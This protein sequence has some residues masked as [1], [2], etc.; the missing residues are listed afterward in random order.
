MLEEAS[1]PGKTEYRYN[2]LNQQTAVFTKDGGVQ[3]NRYDAEY[4]RAEVS[5]NGRSFRFLYYNGELLAESGPDG[6]VAGR[7]ILGYSVAAGWQKEK[8]GYHSYHLDEQNSTAYITGTR[9]GIENSYQYDAFGVIRGRQEGIHNRILYTG[10]QHDQVTEQYY[11]RAR[12]YNPVVGRFL[13]EDVYR[14]DGL[15]L[16]AYCANNPVIYYDPSGFAKRDRTNPKVNSRTNPNIDYGSINQYGQRSGVIAKITPEMIGT[17]TSA[18]GRIKPPG[19]IDGYP[20]S[21]GGAGQARA[22]LLAKDLGGSGSVES[23][24]V[25]FQQ[26]PTNTPKMSNFEQKVK[27]YVNDTGE[28]VYYQVTPLHNNTEGQPYG[29]R[30]EAVSANGEGLNMNE[31][32]IDNPEAQNESN[33]TCT[34]EGK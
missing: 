31:E 32:I 2:A 11:L 4:L 18:S 33:N 1:S 22:H 21:E 30:M 7:Y 10:Q 3:E 6:M 25:T 15:N 29:V 5:E 19:W 9:Q 34:K 14:G 16:Y 28:S 23:N 27:K 17:G 24:L 20:I 12:Y 26:N 13:Q 8:E